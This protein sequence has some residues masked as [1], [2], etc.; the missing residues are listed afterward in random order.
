[1]A[2]NVI[3]IKI[4]AN[5]AQ[6]IAALK[7]VADSAQN[8]GSTLKNA[9]SASG[10]G[11]LSTFSKIG[12]VVTG[13]VA[14]FVAIKAAVENTITPLAKYQSMMEQNSIAFETFLG[15]ADAAKVFFQDLQ[16]MAADTPFELPQL[17]DASKKML[18]FGFAAKD[19]IPTLTAVGDA[20]AGLGGSQEMIQRVTIAI[21]QMKAKGRVQGDELLQL[22][23]AGI[24]AYQILQDQL[25][26]TSKQVQNIGNES[27]N[28]DKAIQALVAG[29][30]AQFGGMMQKQSNT[31]QGMLSTIKDNIMSVG[32]ALTSGLYTKI[33]GIIGKVRDLSNVMATLAKN[34]SLSEAFKDIIPQEV[35][36]KVKNLYTQFSITFISIRELVV[37]FYNASKP[38]LLAFGNLFLSCLPAILEL[39]NVLAKLANSVMPA[40]NGVMNTL[41]GIVNLVANNSRSAI[42]VLAGFAIV[43]VITA[44]VIGLKEAWIGVRKAIV[45]VAM[46][47]MLTSVAVGA[48]TATTAVGK[49]RQAVMLFGLALQEAGRKNIFTVLFALGLAIAGD[50]IFEYVDKLTGS[51]SVTG[52]EEDTRDNDMATRKRLSD[53]DSKDYF[54]RKQMEDQL[55]RPTTDTGNDK[56]YETAQKAAEA[57][58]A[59][60]E[61]T[62]NKVKEDLNAKIEGI[63]KNAKFENRDLLPEEAVQIAQLNRDIVQAELERLTQVKALQE[64]LYSEDP[65]GKHSSDIEKKTQETQTQ[66]D[67]ATKK[68]KGL[69]TALYDFAQATGNLDKILGNSANSISTNYNELVGK[70]TQSGRQWLNRDDGVSRYGDNR[71]DSD[72]V[73]CGQL[74]VK[75]WEG[76]GIDK[77]VQSQGKQWFSA[78]EASWVPDMIKVAKSLGAYHEAGSGYTPKAGDAIIV[79]A[80]EHHAALINES[81]GVINAS[82][83]EKGVYESNT[84]WQDQYPDATGFISL[85]DLAKLK[86]STK[87]TAEEFSKW[88]A[89]NASILNTASE[90]LVASMTNL[91]KKTKDIDD[92]LATYNGDVSTKAKTDIVTKYQPY[93]DTFEKAGQESPHYKSYVEKTKK[94]IQT[95]LNEVDFSQEQE[96]L[97][98]INIELVNSQ[99]NLLI[100][101]ANGSKTVAE[102]T[103]QYSTEYQAATSE[104]IAKMT[105]TM[106][107]A[108]KQKNFADASKIKAQ[109]EKIPTDI[110]AFVESAVSTAQ[111]ALNQKTSLIDV[112]SKMTNMQKTDAKQELQSQYYTD[113]SNAY[114]QAA[115]KIMAI[116]P[117]LQAAGVNPDT[118]I[119]T[120]QNL[121]LYNA[122]LGR[123]KDLTEKVE[124]AGTQAFEDGLLTFLTDGITKCQTLGE[125]FKNLA[126]TVLS[127]IQ[128]VY[129]EAVQKDIMSYFKI[130]DNGGST[131]E[132]KAQTAEAATTL[133][134]AVTPTNQNATTTTAAATVAATTVGGKIDVG[135]TVLGQILTVAQQILTTF[136]TQGTSTNILTG[137]NGSSS[138]SSS[139]G[140]DITQPITSLFAEGGSMDSGPIK[141]PGTGT[142]D[143]IHAYL[144]NFKKHIAISDGEY[145][146]KTAAVKKFGTGFFDKLNNGL[147]PSEFFKVK[148]KFATGGTVSGKTLA[149]PQDIAASLSTGDTNVH[150]KSVNLFDMNQ[151]G[152]YMQSRNGEKVFLNLMK[153]N[154][155]TYSQVLK[156][157]G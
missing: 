24:P 95:Q 101:V 137:T 38:L 23:E 18:A 93:L 56:G 136:Q 87:V 37:S 22:A 103:E 130:G 86:A 39:V 26:L 54:A 69:N 45:T 74:V 102:A 30:N 61:T 59:A 154:A 147:I 10:E 126:N 47:E 52:V 133:V 53:Q 60:L 55:G 12:S 64:S 85:E 28:A 142:S 105:A 107:E 128:K 16:K 46:I 42:T 127:A 139:G 124:I 65:D 71:A 34:G 43:K 148:A 6:A 113:M 157:R 11:F 41:A 100:E 143:S 31:A 91:I 151:I 50:K 57:T 77:I 129:A 66:I 3:E 89:K 27:I 44:M 98:N 29:M 81:G 25:G 122:E 120:M 79:G 13:V 21:G 110:Q 123:T 117:Q 155:T 68:V 73:V 138:S 67:T 80:D 119:R 116:A 70:V 48:A 40:V 78:D 118:I 146:I 144:S 4:T 35:L 90:E 125:A 58:I 121:A 14:G 149:G 115:A 20:V 114:S 109:I 108:T 15:S 141:G 49:L 97:K 150:L 96:D 152:D 76:A 88:Y 5:N 9:G 111:T 72:K 33:E 104:I 83:Q 132:K 92:A 82:G 134:S 36:D 51:K 1:M 2:N 8:T 112:N 131:K 32:A 75:S 156:F 19:V 94:L 140:I 7:Q 153:N 135:N 106:N 99:K 62:A 84:S 17:T 63:Q 145:M